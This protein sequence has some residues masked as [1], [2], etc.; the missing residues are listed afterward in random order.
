MRFRDPRRR[1]QSLTDALLGERWRKNREPG[2]QNGEIVVRKALN[3][4]QGSGLHPRG[5]NKLNEN[6]LHLGVRGRASRGAGL[7]DPLESPI[8][9]PNSTLGHRPQEDRLC[10][11][12]VE[13]PESSARRVGAVVEGS[14]DPS[15]QA[16]ANRSLPGGTGKLR[17]SVP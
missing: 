1:V 16:V 3:Q 6:R 12:A 13:D 10:L 7:W 5:Q 9:A 14:G 8:G 15:G 17:P 4:V 2:T 11:G